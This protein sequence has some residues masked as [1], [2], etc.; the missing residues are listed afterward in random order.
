MDE[1]SSLKWLADQTF[2]EVRALRSAEDN[3]FSWAMSIFLGA[4]GALTGLRGMTVMSWSIP[5]RLLV[6]LGL[7]A[8]VG[9]ILLMAF[10]IRRNYDTNRE[11]LA[12][13]F[14]RLGQADL[15]PASN[16]G[17]LS[18]D[19]LVCYLRWGGFAALGVISLFLVWLLG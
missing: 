13:I 12:N 1:Q 15:Y 7:I 4:F 11:A 10:L 2:Q 18:S 8:A 16:T 14:R 6:I 19:N 9:V 17:M 5:W 3:L